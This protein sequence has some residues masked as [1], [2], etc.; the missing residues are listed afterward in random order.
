MALKAADP[1]AAPPGD[2]RGS[3]SALIGLEHLLLKALTFELSGDGK[4]EPQRRLQDQE[5]IQ[6]AG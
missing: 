3:K 6:E 4:S 2:P 5:G 1:S